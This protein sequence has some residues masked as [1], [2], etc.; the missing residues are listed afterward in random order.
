MN[1]MGSRPHLQSRI[2][3]VPYEK[4]LKGIYQ[5]HADQTVLRILIY[6]DCLSCV[7]MQTEF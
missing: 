3:Y 4:A 6:T 5:I 2:F 7:L 1:T